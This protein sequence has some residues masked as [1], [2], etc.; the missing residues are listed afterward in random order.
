MPDKR[1]TDSSTKC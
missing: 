1:L